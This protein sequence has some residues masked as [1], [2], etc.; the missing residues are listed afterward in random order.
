LRIRLEDVEP[1]VW[2]RVLVPGSVRL[3]RLHGMIQA[4]MGWTDSHLHAFRVGDQRFG[5]RFEDW[6]EDEVDEKEV[7]VLEALRDQR[8]FV[9]EYDFGD[10]WSHEVVIEDL[11]RLPIGL[12]HAV[13]LDGQNAC[14][15][16]DCGG[17]GGYAVLCEALADS[18][19]E[20]HDELSRWLGEPFD[21]AAFDLALVNAALQRV[22]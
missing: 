16:E 12:K 19:H 13:C 15:P 9:Y 21:P 4:A 17:A 20:E 11:R 3:S 5:M 2:R 7:T 22:R 10:S 8:G 1:V 14:P 18:A 6:D